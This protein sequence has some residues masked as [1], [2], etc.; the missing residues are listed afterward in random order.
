MAMLLLAS[1]T[2]EGNPIKESYI[3]TMVASQCNQFRIV[4][5]ATEVQT[6]RSGVARNKMK[7]VRV[8]VK[9]LTSTANRTFKSTCFVDNTSRD[10]IDF[11]AT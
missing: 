2:L 8:Y 4:D 5:I 1:K 6:N 11:F 10:N 7:L 3:P 9:S